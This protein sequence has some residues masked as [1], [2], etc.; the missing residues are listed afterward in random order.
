MT[1]RCLFR[2]L[3][4]GGASATA[5]LAASSALAQSDGAPAAVTA[6]AEE[7][8]SSAEE[9][10]IVIRGV[11][12]S[13]LRSIQAKRDADTIADAISAEELGMFPNRNVAEALAQRAELLRVFR[14]LVLHRGARAALKGDMRTTAQ[15]RYTRR[16]FVLFPLVSRFAL[17]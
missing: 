7:Q 6:Q 3:M 14:S 17:I 9:P 1:G 8:A 15:T 2:D 4:M 13:L 16:P 12:G 11:R 10:E 5:L